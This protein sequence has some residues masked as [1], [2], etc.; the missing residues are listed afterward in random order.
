[1]NTSLRLSG[2]DSVVLGVYRAVADAAGIL[3]IRWVIIGATARDLIYEKAFRITPRRRTRDVDLAIEVEN[4]GRYEQLRMELIRNGAF[5]SCEREY[6]R[7]RCQATGLAIDVI[8]F[9]G[10]EH[11]QAIT[12]PS[13]FA[14]RMS[15]LGLADALGTAIRV[16]LAGDP[17]LEVPV[18]HPGVLV[19]MKLFAWVDRPDRDKD[20]GDAAFMISQY[21]KIFANDDRLFSEHADLLHAVD[22]DLDAAY[23][24]LLG[25]DLASL[26]TSTCRHELQML[27]GAQAELGDDSRLVADMA[28]QSSLSVEQ[29]RNQVAALKRGLHETQ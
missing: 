13:E 22:F 10:V 2:I 25:R 23:A 27:V 4:W 18:V 19:A 9:G 6:Q 8:P 20:A 15:T 28:R 24:E 7:L 1:M 14:I 17:D 12:W 29:C 21:G 5:R 16:V 11:D 3:R 26:L